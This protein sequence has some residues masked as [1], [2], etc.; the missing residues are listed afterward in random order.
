[1]FF[2][3]AADRLQFTLHGVR[4]TITRASRTEKVPIGTG[5]VNDHHDFYVRAT[6]SDGKESYLTLF[7]SRQTIEQLVDGGRAEIVY[8]RDNPRRHLM[9]GEALPS[10]GIGWLIFGLAAFPVFL[11]SL[12]L[13]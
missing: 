3:D 13:D 5:W 12:R 10:A 11:R 7:L 1:M 4:A 8:V 9:K 2:A 6:A